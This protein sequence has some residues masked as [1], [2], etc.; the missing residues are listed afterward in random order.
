MENYLLSKDT[1]W[2]IDTRPPKGMPEYPELTLGGM[3]LSRAKLTAYSKTSEEMA[4]FDKLI[5]EMNGVRSQ[6]RVAWEKKAAHG[7][8]LR[9]RMWR[10]FIEDYRRASQ[11]NADRYP[12]EVRLRVMLTL[13]KSEGGGKNPAEADLLIV[14][15]KFL[16]SALIKNSFLW[17][18]E[19]QPGFPEETHWYLYG[20]LPSMPFED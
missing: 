6:W 13:L 9:L 10:D 11:D 7:F 18:A 1:F 3:L 15:D 16:K 12:Y 5:S 14:L 8:S 19:L 2:P 20:R 4:Q 17:E